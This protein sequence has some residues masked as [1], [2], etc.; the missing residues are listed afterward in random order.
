MFIQQTQELLETVKSVDLEKVLIWKM[1]I[2]RVYV[3]A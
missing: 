1:R 3:S 2:N